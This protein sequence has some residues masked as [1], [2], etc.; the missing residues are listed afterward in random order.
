M[1]FCLVDG[2][3]QVGGGALPLLE[4]P[5][6]MMAVEL[7][8]ASP[9]ELEGRLRRCAVPIIGRIH[10]GSFLLDLRTITDSDIPPLVSGLRSLAP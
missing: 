8:H 7:D 6:V 4:L 2:F 10:K 1:K 9:Q 3:S 5:T